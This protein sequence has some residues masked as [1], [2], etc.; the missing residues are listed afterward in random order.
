M[1]I[2]ADKKIAQKASPFIGITE[3]KADDCTYLAVINYLPE[4]VEETIT[5]KE[6]RAVA[7]DS[8]DGNVELIEN[9]GGFKLRLPANCGALVTVK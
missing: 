3:H 1:G 8:V 6:G 4:A 7:V 9:E 2:G 5:L